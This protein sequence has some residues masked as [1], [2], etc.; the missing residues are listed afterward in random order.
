[1]KARK[2]FVSNSSTSSFVF[3]GFIGDNLNFED[4][5]EAA[6][7]VGCDLLYGEE[8]GLPENIKCVFGKFLLQFSDEDYTEAVPFDWYTAKNEVEQIRNRLR[9]KLR[10]GN[11]NR[12]CGN[13]RILSWPLVGRIRS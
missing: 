7:K 6:E 12:R 2:G 3:V 5:W 1:M 8:D 10:L 9:A 4:P 13:N 11:F